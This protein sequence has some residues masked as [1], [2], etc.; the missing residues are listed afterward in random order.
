MTHPAATTHEP[1][2]TGDGCALWYARAVLAD[3]PQ[4]DDDTVAAACTLIEA[5]SP[6]PTER[7]R[8]ADLRTLIEGE[9]A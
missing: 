8:A 3:A 4:H 2:R 1:G 7:A 9:T 6:D 5:H